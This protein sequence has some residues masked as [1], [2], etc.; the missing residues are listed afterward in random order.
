MHWPLHEGSLEITLTVP[1]I[2]SFRELQNT[3]SST[4]VLENMLDLKT[5]FSEKNTDFSAVD[6]QTNV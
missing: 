3:N 4:E 5:R 1:L 6:D 2:C